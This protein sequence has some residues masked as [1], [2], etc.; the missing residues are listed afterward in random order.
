[1]SWQQ[2]QGWMTYAHHEPFGEQRADLRM[3]IL[4]SLIYNA[5]RSPKSKAL[6]AADFMP[7]FGGAKA[8]K[9][10]K[11]LTSASEW[12]S[13]KQIVATNYAREGR[14]EKGP[15]RPKKLNISDRRRRMLEARGTSL[16]EV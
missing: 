12:S 6:T 5:N 3:S 8:G 2:L 13:L 10:R 14:A 4:A 15:K 1:M 9:A 16:P 7:K 11:P